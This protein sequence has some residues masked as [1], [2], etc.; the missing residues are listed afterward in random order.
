MGSQ[1]AA[2]STRTARRAARE[3][4]ALLAAR[5]L[6]DRMRGLYRELEQLTAAPIGMH[7]ALNAIGAAPGIQASRLAQALG[8]DAAVLGPVL[9]TASH[10][11][12]PGIGWEA[13]AALREDVALPIYAIGGLQRDDV[14]IARRHG[15]Q[16]IAAIRGLWP[17]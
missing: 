4:R 6:V 14:A 15:A 10:P 9:P 16:G 17:G 5:A 8:C 1:R 2:S 13:F 7:R 12:Q 11:G 3:H